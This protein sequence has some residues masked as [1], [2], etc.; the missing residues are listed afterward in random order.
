VVERDHA[1]LDDLTGAQ[2]SGI[3]EITRN[4]MVMQPKALGWTRPTVP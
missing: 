4:G 3:S 2:K 1:A